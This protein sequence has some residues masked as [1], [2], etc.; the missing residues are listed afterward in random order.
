METLVLHPCPGNTEL[1]IW[2]RAAWMKYIYGINIYRRVKGITR[3]IHPRT[4]QYQQLAEVYPSPLHGDHRFT[5]SGKIGRTHNVFYN[6]GNLNTHWRRENKLGTKIC[7]LLF[8]QHAEGSHSWL[9]S[10]PEWV[11]IR[12]SPCSTVFSNFTPATRAPSL[13][14]NISAG[15]L[16]NTN[17]SSRPPVPW[18]VE[19]CS[20]AA[21]T[22]SS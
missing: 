12:K 7:P 21:F 8:T 4:P 20:P 13:D 18:L 15:F 10:N 1:G 14:D 22:K 2:S 19:G 11:E 3:T 9:L 5:R 6:V 16:K 17:G